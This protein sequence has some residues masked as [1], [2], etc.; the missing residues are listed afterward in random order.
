MLD[1][2]VAYNRYKFIGEEFL[3]WLW[4]LIDT[5]QKRLKSIDNEIDGLEV[6]ALRIP[7]LKRW[8][9]SGHGPTCTFQESRAPGGDSLRTGARWV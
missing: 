2:A 3:T 8:T 5:G 7:G 4:F 9:T 6:G 1:V